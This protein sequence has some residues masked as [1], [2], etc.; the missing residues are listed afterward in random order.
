M[1]RKLSPAKIN[2]HLAVLGKRP[3]GYHN[4]AS[5]MQLVGLYDELT[6][7]PQAGNIVINCPDSGLPV[8]EDNIVFRAARAIFALKEYAGGVKIEIRKEIPI[9]AGLGGGS[10]NAATTLLA[11][12][13]LFCFHLTLTELLALGKNLGADV[14]FFIFGKTAWAT[15]IGEE[16]TATAPLPP[17]WLVL[18]NPGFE[19]STRA[20]YESLNL[21]LT[22]EPVNYSIPA[23]YSQDDLIRGL[24]NDLEAAAIKLH[25]EIE[26][27]KRILISAGALG[28]MM[29]GSGPTV[30]GIFQTE[31][32]ARE[33]ANSIVRRVPATWRIIVSCSL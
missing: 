29:S 6:F 30:F 14:P 3:D 4:I 33:A 20:I 9:A 1:M 18:V 19:L 12:N 28:S 22:T 7:E 25:P 17:S 8:N 15:G 23:I 10:G 32:R 5:L 16:L 27:I 26:E 24:K 21:R 2:L 13:E 31:K 11:L